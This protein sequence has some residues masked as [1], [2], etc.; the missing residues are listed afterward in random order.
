MD[1]NL[2]QFVTGIIS[3]GLQVLEIWK[4]GRSIKDVQDKVKQFDEITSSQNI[5]TEGLLLEGLVP[6]QV[7]NTL[8]RRVEICWIDFNEV[9]ENQNLTPRQMDRYTEGLRECIC[10]ELKIIRRLNGKLPAKTMQDWWNE[11]ECA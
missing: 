2:G 10:R 9:A 1:Y 6:N 4:D 3:V 8:K 11:Y 5:L 7:L